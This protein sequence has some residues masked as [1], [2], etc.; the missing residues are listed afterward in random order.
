LG[1]I[2]VGKP[3]KAPG[4]PCGESAV[5]SSGFRVQGIGFEIQGSGFRVQVWGKT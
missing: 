5:A 1:H 4:G 2:E 3:L